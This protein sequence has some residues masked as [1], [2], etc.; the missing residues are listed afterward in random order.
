MNLWR[1]LG[2]T[3]FLVSLTCFISSGRPAVYAGD[4]K[5]EGK[6]DEGKK[7]PPKVEQ[8]PVKG[9]GVVFTLSAFEK[10]TPFF[11]SYETDTTQTMKV[12]GQD[13]TQKQ[14]QT[15]FV[16][17][18]PKDKDKD[19]NYVV[20]QKIIGVV[21]DID[22]GGNKISYD[23]RKPQQP[24]NPMT[25]FFGQLID[26]SLTF[27]ISPKLKVT[28][29]EGRKALVDA[30]G[31]TNPQ[32]VPL[33]NSILSEAALKQMA[34]PTWA[35]V[36]PNDAVAGKTE[37][38]SESQLDL[39]PIGSYTSNFKFKYDS[40]DAKTKLDKITIT[41]DVKYVAPTGKS[42]LPFTISAANLK[43]TSG[44]GEAFF[45][46]AKGRFEKSSINMKL[47]G[48]LTIVVGGMTT[49][50]TLSQTQIATVTTTDTN[51]IPAAAPDKK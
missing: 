32:M 1:W 3:L 15:F 49:D 8:P 46:R 6:K 26:K 20:E 4:K 25:E 39:G 30:L 40:E 29:I 41:T 22:I 10:K 5:D 27:T 31:A 44:A 36:P 45:D 12:M 23:S 34:E 17:W 9:S 14:K 11:Q 19:G 21:M 50:I 18:T 38:A 24:K 35:A 28:G 48:T 37:W 42:D 43:S 51:P 16:Q 13:V 47:D 2:A 7:D 33:L